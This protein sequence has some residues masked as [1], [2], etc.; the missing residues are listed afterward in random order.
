MPNILTL[1]NISPAGLNEFDNHNFTVS[2]T[3]EKP[4]AILLRSFNLHDYI[5]PDSVTLIARAGAGTNNIPLNHMTERGI[6]VLNTPGANANA[7]KE[8]VITGMLLACRNICSAWNYVNQL[9]AH[10]DIHTLIESQKKLFAG[11]EL[12]GKTLGI[13][14]LGHIGVKVANAADALEMN[15]IGYDP[16]M[17][18]QNAWELSASVKQAESIEAVLRH[19]DFVSIHV[20]LIDATRNLINS[21]TLQQMRKGAIL[22]NFARTGI[23]DNDALLAALKSQQLS[24]YVCDFPEATLLNV[25]NIICLPHLG[26]S[27][28]EAEENC[29]VMAARQMIDFFKTG[30]IHHS[31]NFPNVKLT[32]SQ[33]HRIAIVNANIPNMVAQISSVFSQDQCNIIDMINKSRHNI[34][35]T[36]IDVDRAITPNLLQKLN[37]IDG[38]I[39]TRIIQS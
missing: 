35:Y 39:R 14:G 8:L 26:A 1:N 10:D 7:V 21:Q 31:V 27:T 18:V 25:P 33:G 5:I 32:Q 11:F 34:A 36:L 3:I 22:L 30:A 29:A 20:P 15:V 37:A 19:A 12:P 16:A 17:T 6:P 9:N 2:S 38:V 13:I 28:R 23:V 24:H 4:D